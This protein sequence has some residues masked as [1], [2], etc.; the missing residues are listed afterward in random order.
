MPLLDRLGE[1]AGKRFGLEITDLP[2]SAVVEPALPRPARLMRQ[3]PPDLDVRIS[4]PFRELVR[5]ADGQV[6]ADAA[7]FARGILVEGDIDAALALR[8]ALD[9]AP[10]SLLQ[11]FAACHGPFAAPAERLVRFLLRRPDPA[12]PE[13]GSP[14][15]ATWI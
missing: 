4:G 14:R 6:D 7:F 8:N 5:I 15:E 13:A 2:I 11:A 12:S 10:V 1:H 3:L 9:T